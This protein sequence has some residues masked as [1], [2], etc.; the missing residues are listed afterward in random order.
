MDPVVGPSLLIIKCTHDH[1]FGT[2]PAAKEED[3]LRGFPRPPTANTTQ[4]EINR[5]PQSEEISRSRQI[6]LLGQVV[7]SLAVTGGG[8]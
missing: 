8:V 3:S 5:F 2:C 1:L 7:C 4:P 6:R